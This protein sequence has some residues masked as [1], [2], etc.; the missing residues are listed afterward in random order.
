MSSRRWGAA[1]LL[2]VLLGLLALMLSGTVRVR[3]YQDVDRSKTEEKPRPAGK[4]T[5]ATRRAE[6]A[7]LRKAGEAYSK[8][9][10]K[11]DLDTLA[12]FWTE[13]ADF[14]NEA[15]KV[16]NGRETI[17][18]LLK[19]SLAGNKGFKQSVRASNF[20]FIKPDVV[21]IEGVV[22]MTMPEGGVEKGRYAAIWV[23][24]GGKWLISSMRD[25]PELEGED[26]PAATQRL[27]QLAWLVG[28]WEDKDG[29][30]QVTMTVRWGPNQT[31][32]IQRFTVK[33]AGG[34]EVH[35]TQR[36]GWNPIEEQIR[37]WLFDSSGGF[38]GGYW[39]RRGNTWVE[40][41][42]GTS[43]DGQVLTALNTWKFVDDNTAEWT[44]RD[45][46]VDEAPQKDLRVV[47][48]RKNKGR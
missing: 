18:S 46:E 12:G 14:I 20:R 33:Q 10:N 35:T 4:E 45:R 7:A 3:A 31:Y 39:T 32:L 24:Q 6:E 15:G 16:Y 36:I 44:S 28:D 37:S 34:K 19:A 30:G 41:N 11:G 2:A 26:T 13:D 43:S 22:T 29:K 5:P 23:K 1:A 47:F 38:A 25:L 42:E 21:R 8:A 48:V 27:R 9:W 40:D 17:R